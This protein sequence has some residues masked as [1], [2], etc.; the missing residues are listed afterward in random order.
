M[1]TIGRRSLI[2]GAAAAVAALR[3]KGAAMPLP[4]PGRQARLVDDPFTL[5]L[6][7]GDPTSSGFVAWTRL[8]PDPTAGGGMAPDP[9][10]VSYE[11]ASDAGFAQVVRTG[12]VTAIGDL[13]HT[14]HLDVGGLD[15][16][17]EWWVR[18]T[19]EGFD[20]PVARAR[21]LPDGG[22]PP[23]RFGFV[24]CQR[25]PNGYYTALR[26][27]AEEDCDLWLHLGDYIYETPGTGPVRSHGDSEA[28]TLN[29][30]RNRYGTYKSD[31]D[32]QAAHHSAPVVPVWDDH[33]VDNDYADEVGENDQTPAEIR[34]RRT[35]GYRAWFE[36]QPVRL[37]APTG[38]D[39]QIYRRF[40]WGDL[41]TFH[42]LDDRQYRDPPPCGGE[43][44]ECPERLSGDRSMLGTEQRSWLADG[45]AG[46]GA[47]WDVVGQQVVFV[48]L[49]FGPL[50]NNAQWDGYPQERELVWDL[51]KTRPNP[52]IVTGD[53][54][55]AGV[56]RLHED[57]DDVDTPRIGTELVGTSVSSTF[58]PALVDAAE[59]L[60]SS[61]PYIE[62]V[63]AG[64]RGYTIVDLTAEHMRAEYKVVDQVTSPGGTISSAYVLELDARA[65]TEV[66][67]GDP[68]T[69]PG[70]PGTPPGGPGGPGTPGGPG[71]PGTPGG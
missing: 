64:Q 54:H 52:V 35:A 55:A 15:P 5:G 62:Y 32:L 22:T 34:A 59:A 18:F 20:S 4:V 44:A 50:Y 37:T 29:D 45:L 51:L 28:V 31:L 2:V 7:T 41:A 3:L 46:S 58:N 26:G 48:P 23:L 27:L 49:P 17:S 67:I 53:I 24:S 57:L 36:H 68:G 70:D 10:A 19:A 8:A 6:A 30:Y 39:L 21:T 25:Y 60:I 9:V 33:E 47:V 12:E 69:P 66:P 63:N 43:L 56:A 65:A 40:A 14:V 61:L 16:A 71:G 1:E 11:V 13:A 38:P 42:M